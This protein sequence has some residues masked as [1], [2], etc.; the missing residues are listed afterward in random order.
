MEATRVEAKV[1]V[2]AKYN[3]KHNFRVVILPEVTY[4]LPTSAWELRERRKTWVIPQP[5]VTP[6]RKKNTP[7]G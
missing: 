7:K 5:S 6:T 1:D 2:L 4:A 3:A